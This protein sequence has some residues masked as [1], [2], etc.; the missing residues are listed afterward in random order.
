MFSTEP[1]FVIVP[2]AVMSATS[3][4]TNPSPVTVTVGL[5][6]GVPSYGFVASSLASF[7]V[8]GVIL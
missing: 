3:P 2:V 8:L 6:N 5:V 7:T 1:T 4:S